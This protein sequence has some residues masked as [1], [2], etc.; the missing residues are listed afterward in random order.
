VELL[1]V[2][3]LLVELLVV[4]PLLE[5][6]L[7]QGP[8]TPFALPTGTMQLEPGQQSASIVHLPQVCTHAGAQMYGGFPAGLGTQ[9][10]SLQQFALDAH[11]PP[12]MTQVAPLHRGTP[13]LSGLQVSWWQ[14]PLQ[15]SQLAEHDMVDSRQTSPSGLQLLGFR[16]VPTVLGATMVQVTYCMFGGP[17]GSPIEPQQSLSLVHRSPTGWQPLARWQTRTRSGP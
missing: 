3:L 14:L 11:A 1:V 16:Q 5:L 12:G 10:R 17:P 9:G 2:P 4:V 7:V 15:Q 6:L 8:Q 13:R